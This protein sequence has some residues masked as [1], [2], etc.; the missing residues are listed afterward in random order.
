YTRS[1]FQVVTIALLVSWFAAVVFVP[2]LGDRLLPDLAKLHAAKH[3]GSAG[4]HDPYSTAFYQRVRRVV[5]W[6][7]E[8]RKTVI[9]STL[10]LFIGS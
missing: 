1:I 8:R 2:Y 7:V 6:C 5:G 3:G 9:V 10:V 4:G